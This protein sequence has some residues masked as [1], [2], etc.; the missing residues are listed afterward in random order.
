MTIDALIITSD[1]TC[2]DTT[3]DPH[4]RMTAASIDSLTFVFLLS[5]LFRI[6]TN[7]QTELQH[8]F[9]TMRDLHTKKIDTITQWGSQ[10]FFVPE[11]KKKSK[12]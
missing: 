4:L 1:D 2:A 12:T 5:F 8:K 3:C 10:K 11:S 7:F 9:S 6:I